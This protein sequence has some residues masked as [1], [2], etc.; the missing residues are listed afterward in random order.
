ME[1]IHN[2]KLLPGIKIYGSIFSKVCKTFLAVINSTKLDL[3]TLSWVLSGFCVLDF[4]LF[5]ALVKY[6]DL[7]K[8]YV[9]VRLGYQ[10][11]HEGVHSSSD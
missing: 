7:G 6:T 3:K 8:L 4:F 5:V 1:N 10:K 2:F 11:L 9:V